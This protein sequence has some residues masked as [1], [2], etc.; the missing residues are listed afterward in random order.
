[1]KK[2][3]SFL[4]AAAI[5][6]AGTFVPAYAAETT[7]PAPEAS[8]AAAD[9]D[10]APIAPAPE[11]SPEPDE[12]PAPE[13][14]PEPDESP[15][16][17]KSPEPD[18]SPAPEESPEPD[19]SPTPEE[20]PEPEESPT[21]DASPTPEPSPAPALTTEHRPYLSGNQDQ[22]FPNKSLT[23]AEAAVI[24][25]SLLETVPESAG[26][27]SFPDVAENSWYGKQVLALSELGVFTGGSNGLFAPGHSITRREFVIVLS[28][29]FPEEEEPVSG[30]SFPDI[31]ESMWGSKAIYTAAARGWISGCDD[32]NFQ[33]DRG[34]TRAE[35]AVIL[36]NAL[37]RKP[38][39]D[40][41]KA[42]GDPLVFLDL[43][44]AHWAYAQIM[45]AALEHTHT[46]GGEKWASFQVPAA[47]HKPGAH[48]IGGELY[49]V[50]ANG[51]WVRNQT[52]GVLRF[53]A[54][55]RYT[56]GN[57]ALDKQL[58]AIV[59]A[60]VKEGDTNYNNFKRLH[61]FVTRKY[62]YRAGSYIADGGT[63]WEAGLALEMI[64][65]GKGN[66]YRFAALDTMLARKLGFQATGVSGEIDTGNGFV[67]HG[68]VQIND[69][70]K[71]L[72]C[73]PEIQYVRP[74]WDLFMKSYRAVSS[75]YRV[76][77][78]RRQ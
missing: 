16:P 20:S 58:T 73:D 29:F 54:N 25:Y 26:G 22:V 39:R 17:D 70:G 43:T 3:L 13:E 47:S 45:E 48:L 33:P 67:P 11:E 9:S 55:G 50:D 37:N 71:I 7:G 35:A 15:T 51:H 34:I 1:M 61:L 42:G 27:V 8:S 6:T 40:K 76:Q 38:D 14:S 69:N 78:V 44:P 30:V 5:L 18:E 75:R 56:T 63:G 60:N 52:A 10:I 64:Q 19:G 68:W 4:L 28:H 46:D 24:L 21:P 72:L 77:G 41:L 23:R 53:D 74:D 59:K 12:S 32:G 57:A 62:A 2:I 31:T 36:N 66:C 49:Y 65:N